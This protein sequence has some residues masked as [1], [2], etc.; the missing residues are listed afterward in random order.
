[1]IIQLN[2]NIT[3][4]SNMA[5]KWKAV[6]LPEDLVKRIDKFVNSKKA[7]GQAY[8]SVQTFITRVS[9]AKLDEL[10]KN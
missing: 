6:Q 1:M 9:V 8:T 5:K 4:M 2:Y 7:E 10:E 3:N